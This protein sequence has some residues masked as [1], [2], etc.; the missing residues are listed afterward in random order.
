M[1]ADSESPSPDLG[2]A[3][4][5]VACLCSLPWDSRLFIF[6]HSLVQVSSAQKL[7]VMLTVAATTQEG[8]LFVSFAI[9]DLSYSTCVNTDTHIHVSILLNNI[10]LNAL[11]T[12]NNL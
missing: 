2:L 10:E 11:S 7:G 5:Y 8:A 3:L 4:S 12:S 1:N 6:P 9:E